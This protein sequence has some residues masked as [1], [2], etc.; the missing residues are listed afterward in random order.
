M[1]QSLFGVREQVMNDST[2]W[3][4]LRLFDDGKGNDALIWFKY[5][6]PPIETLM[7]GSPDNYYAALQL[8]YPCMER[9]YQLKEAKVGKRGLTNDVLK[10][11]FP[12]GEDAKVEEYEQIMS[13]VA[14]QMR[15]GLAPDAFVREGAEIRDGLVSFFDSGLSNDAYRKD[16]VIFAGFTRPISRKVDG[17]IA[18]D[19]R[20]FWNV[21]K[22]KIDDYYT[23]TVYLVNHAK[24]EEINRMFTAI[25]QASKAEA[26]KDI[27]KQIQESA[28]KTRD[29]Q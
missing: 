14:N 9:V 27:L 10:D 6:R 21:V 7:N 2:K 15:H 12:P 20:S 4:G 16:A 5:W 1:R 8:M 23:S 3:L 22:S 18:V 26:K 25:W 17:K 13:D 28:Y 11:F 29:S 24:S 19:V